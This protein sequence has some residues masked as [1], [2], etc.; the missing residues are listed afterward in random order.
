MK[1]RIKGNSIRLRLTKSEVL[2][3]SETGVIEEKTDFGNTELIYRLASSEGPDLL[4]S[5]FENN[6]VTVFMNQTLASAWYTSDEVGYKHIFK[7][8]DDSEI[9]L[10]VEK[11]FVCLDETFEDQSDNYDNPNASC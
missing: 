6:V 11:D 4:S 7:T 10:L 9:F 3:F 5:S 8:S 2:Q 1:L